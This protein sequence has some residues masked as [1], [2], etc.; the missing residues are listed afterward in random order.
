MTTINWGLQDPNAYQRGYQQSKGIFDE[1]AATRK[2]N[3]LDAALRDYATNPDDPNAV[4][5]LAQVDPRLAIQVRQQQ[6][7]AQGKANEDYRESMKAGGEIVRRIQQQNPQM[8]KEQVY[9]VARQAAIS[10]RIPGADQ[11][12]PEFNEQYFNTLLYAADPAKTAQ[13]PADVQEYEYAKGQG[14]AGTYMQFKEADRGPI[15]ANNGDGTFTL[16]PRGAAPGPA[17]GAGQMPRITTPEE[18]DALPPGSRFIAPDGSVR[19]KPGGPTP[20]ASGGFPGDIDPLA[21]RF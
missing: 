10:M 7:Q 2:Q 20:P 16:I 21:P 11:A 8:P 6:A 3:T 1:L 5:A 19:T 14:Y 15:V 9:S 18:A 12:P 13:Q 4:N 17:P